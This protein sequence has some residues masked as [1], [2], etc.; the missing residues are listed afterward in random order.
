MIIPQVK[1]GSAARNLPVFS[2]TGSAPQI[3]TDSSGNWE[4]VFTKDFEITF[5]RIPG[6]VDIF[7]VGGGG[8]AGSNAGNYISRTNVYAQGGRGGGGGECITRSGMQLTAGQTYSGSIGKSGT[9]T[10]AFGIT[11]AAGALGGGAAGAQCAYQYGSSA[12][13]YATDAGTADAGVLA[14]GDAD[15]LYRPGFLYGADGGGGSAKAYTQEGD[16]SAGGTSGGGSG[17]TGDNFGSGSAGAA[18]S[19]GGGGGG[20][21]HN[22]TVSGSPGLGGSGI[23]IMRNARVSS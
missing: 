16:A 13:T 9:S 20:A 21:R 4:L 18:N 10:S 17:G 22:D 1:Y 19:G 7:V 15:T 14:F 2:V 11:A 12:Q 8:K 3:L 23:V 6:P 5:S